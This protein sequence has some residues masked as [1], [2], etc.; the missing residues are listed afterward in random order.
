[1]KLRNKL[2][3]TLLLIT[4]AILFTALKGD[5]KNFELSKQ[6]NIFASL[7]RDVNLFY[8]DTVNSE[9]LMQEGVT[10]MLKSLDPYTVYYPEENTDDVKFMTTGEY[11]GIGAVISQKGDYVI[12]REPYRNTPSFKAGLQPGDRLLS[13]DGENVKGMTTVEV[14]NRLRGVP[15]KELVLKIERGEKELKTVKLIREKVQTPAVPYYG[16]VKEGVGYIYLTSFTDKSGPDVRKALINLKNQGATSMI[17]DLRGNSGGLLNQAVDIVGYFMPRNTKV[18]STKGKIKQAEG[19]MFTR[20]NP[21]MPD[22]PLVVLINSGSASASEIVSGALQDHDRAVLI[23]SRSYGKGL[24]QTVR[25]LPYNT[26]VKLT[27]AKYYIP[28]GRCIQAIDYSHRNEDGSVGTIPDSLINEFATANGRKVFDGGGITPDIQTDREK[29]ARISQEL[30]IEDLIF[31]FVNSY[32]LNHPTIPA[33]KDFKVSDALYQ[34]FVSY[35]ENQKF[36]YTTASQEQLEKL[37][38]TAKSEKYYEANEKQIELLRKELGHSIARDMELHKEQIRNFLADQFI[39]RYYQM[40]GVIEYGTLNDKEIKKAIEVLQNQK[41]YNK[42][43]NKQ[44]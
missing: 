1:M 30:I 35:L 20:N 7:Y 29:L 12:I 19:E 2:T 14:T 10:A 37:I 39:Q 9:K 43:L 8:V 36:D 28:S 33:I 25:D 18:V 17:L 42:I 16:M 24:V 15:G 6:L 40:E 21:I 44:N 31:D 27:T 4:T 34:E 23:G 38:E 5:D 32:A 13:I 11:A 26:K 41:D 3:I 22:M